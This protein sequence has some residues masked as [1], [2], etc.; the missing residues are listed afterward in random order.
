MK[1]ISMH[2]VKISQI[3]SRIQNDI[4]RAI[5]FWQRV[6]VGYISSMKK[7]FITPWQM[8][9]ARV[10]WTGLAKTL[11]STKHGTSAWMAVVALAGAVRSEG[12]NVVETGPHCWVVQVIREEADPSGET[13]LVPDQWQGLSTG[14]NRWDEASK[15]CGP[16]ER[17]FELQ[18]IGFIK[19]RN[20]T[21]QPVLSPEIRTAEAREIWEQNNRRSLPIRQLIHFTGWRPTTATGASLFLQ[22]PKFNSR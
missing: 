16:G 11:D 1:I 19:L 17:Q 2:Y 14:F 7:A 6:H 18:D 9:C 13:K 5:W 12:I 22:N 21:H 15:P 4:D 8:K 3:C 20:T 10:V